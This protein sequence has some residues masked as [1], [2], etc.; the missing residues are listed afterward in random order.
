MAVSPTAGR[1]RFRRP[2]VLPAS[3]ETLGR[4]ICGIWKIRLSDIRRRKGSYSPGSDAGRDVFGTSNLRLL[5]GPAVG[6]LPD[7]DA[8][9]HMFRCSTA[10]ITIRSADSCS[11]RYSE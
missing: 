8:Q 5:L 4:K 7:R 3:E 6:E 10:R 9:I 1:P 2:I 11:G